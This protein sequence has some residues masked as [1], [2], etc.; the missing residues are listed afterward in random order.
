MAANALSR[1]DRNWLAGLISR[2]VPLAQ[3]PEALR[4]QPDDIKVVID[5]TT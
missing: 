4:R 3:W 1:A 2:R 5:F